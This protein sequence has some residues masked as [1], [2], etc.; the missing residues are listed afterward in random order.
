M[1][2]RILMVHSRTCKWK[3]KAFKTKSFWHDCCKTWA[4]LSPNPMSLAFMF[5]QKNKHSVDISLENSF[6]N[7]A[8]FHLSWWVHLN[9][10]IEYTLDKWKRIFSTWKKKRGLNGCSIF[11]RVGLYLQKRLTVKSFR[12]WNL[13]KT[14]KWVLNDSWATDWSEMIKYQAGKIR[15]REIKSER[16][17]VHLLI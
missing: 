4:G 12:N 13:S 7:E 9:V 1:P 10:A 14:K 15:K 17:Y 16:V 5:D 8:K 3:R 6:H 2:Q 11:L